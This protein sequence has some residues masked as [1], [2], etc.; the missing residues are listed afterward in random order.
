[1]AVAVLLAACVAPNAASFVPGDDLGTPLADRA[2]VNGIVTDAEGN[3]IANVQILVHMTS[4]PFT[5]TLEAIATLEDGTFQLV[6]RP[7]SYTIEAYLE[8]REA[9]EDVELEAGEAIELTLI[10]DG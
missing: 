9:D 6:E 4:P 2:T 5:N 7:G 3:P 10:L 1:M 8:G